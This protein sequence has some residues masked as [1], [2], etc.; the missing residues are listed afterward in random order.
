MATETELRERIKI[1][2]AEEGTAK[3]NRLAGAAANVARA[4]GGVVTL[5]GV[6][7]GIA[8]VLK[9]GQ[10]VTEADKLFKA[11]SRVRD[12][13]GQSARMTHAMFQAFE[14]G[15]VGLEDAERVMM[16]M[17][18][19]SGKVGGSVAVT[20][21]Q[22]R[23]M[24]RRMR[25][26]G[27][28]IKAGPSQQLIQMARAAQA[29]KLKLHDLSAVFGIQ[30]AQARQMFGMLRKGPEAISA[31]YKE[32]LKSSA[33]IDQRALDSYKQM[34]RARRELGSAWNDLVLILYKSLIPA[35]TTILVR[36]KDGFAAA[37]P[38]VKRIGE[39]MARN[40]ETIVAL[41]KTYI[42]LLV[43]SKALNLF[44]ANPM[45][46][47]ARG[48]QVLGGANAAMAGYAA[49]RNPTDY[50]AA[51]AA[52]P[53]IGMFEKAG[54][55]LVRVLGSLAGRLGIIGVVV[56]AVIGAFALLKRNVLGIRD[57][58][59]NAFGRIIDRVKSIFEKLWGV[60]GKLFEALKPVA[61]LLGGAFLV[62]LRI[63]VFWVETFAWV[64][65]KVMSAIVAIINAV[66]WAINKLPGVDIDYINLDKA[67]TKADASKKSTPQGKE[68]TT[69]YQDF[70]GSKFEIHNNFPQGVDSGRIA[71]GFGDQLARL[72]ERRVDSGVR[73]IYAYR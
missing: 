42:G 20:A 36:I 47:F 4:F 70:R 63:A 71:V 23:E 65:D 2:G 67:K 5:G 14:A 12:V 30:G 68:E 43:A 33:L 3:L 25:A 37:E 40:M 22:A 52:N 46:V 41:T 19:L 44:S 60:V 32:T 48:K 73:P 51:M 45:G 27:V 6:V 72:G 9:V 7:G 56:M 35:V 11:I 10:A 29:G 13:T 17:A 53:G 16:S 8:G 69:V 21:D 15:G 54:G 38:V 62:T 49:K 34:S 61:A 18:R 39:F 1:D 66:I 59:T 64:M 26:L 24:S 57:S 55:P 28:D 50:F 31:T 58:F